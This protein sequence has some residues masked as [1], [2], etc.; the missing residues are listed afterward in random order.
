MKKICTAAAAA[1]FVVSTPIYSGSQD[2][3]VATSSCNEIHGAISLVIAYATC[4][5]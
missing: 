3:F 4:I 2:T 1:A 5:Y